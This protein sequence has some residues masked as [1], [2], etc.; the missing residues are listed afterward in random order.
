MALTGLPAG[1]APAC[2]QIVF[3]VACLACSA[4]WTNVWWKYR[5]STWQVHSMLQS[6]SLALFAS[7]SGMLLSSF[8]LFAP[9]LVPKI[10]E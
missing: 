4:R 3:C 2:S 5:H 7:V 8:L 9:R 6:V 10:A 1:A